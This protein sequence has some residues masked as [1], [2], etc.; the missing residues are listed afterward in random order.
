MLKVIPADLSSFGNEVG[1]VAISPP[2][3]STMK[4]S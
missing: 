4:P 2:L 1:G 3:A